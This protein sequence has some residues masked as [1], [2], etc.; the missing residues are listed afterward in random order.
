[1]ALPRLSPKY[2]AVVS[3]T[4][5]EPWWRTVWAHL[6]LLCWQMDWFQPVLI[7]GVCVVI[8]LAFHLPIHSVLHVFYCT[9]SLQSNC[10][11]ESYSMFRVVPSDV[12]L[13]AFASDRSHMLNTDGSWLQPPPTYPCIHTPGMRLL[14]LPHRMTSFCI[15]TFFYN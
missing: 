15:G 14:L 5:E 7:N 11:N 4:V 1:M 6:V 12:Y 3:E 8:C 9:L 10:V 13:S 2:A